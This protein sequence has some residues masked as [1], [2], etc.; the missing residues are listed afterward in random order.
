VPRPAQCLGPPQALDAGAV[1]VLAPGAQEHELPGWTW[2]SGPVEFTPNGAQ[3][4]GPTDL[5]PGR[6]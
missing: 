5:E 3:A 6:V 4:A 2:K 1:G